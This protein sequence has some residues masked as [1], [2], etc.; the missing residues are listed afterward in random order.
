MTPFVE[1][2]NVELLES[3]RLMS[4]GATLGS[5]GVLSIQG[6]DAADVISVAPNAV[7][8]VVA[9]SIN[10]AY[11][12]FA[13]ASV[14][15]I[16]AKLG[17]GNDKFDGTYMNI[18]MTVDGEAGNDSILGGSANDYLIGGLDADYIFGGMGA[19]NI[20]GNGGKDFLSGGGGVDRLDG[21]KSNDVL[22]GGSGND[23]MIGG[24]GNDML[25][26]DDGDDLFYCGGVYSDTLLGG[27]GADRGYVDAD[28]KCY[29]IETKTMT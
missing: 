29:S 5:T 10:G 6:T 18:P 9:V 7:K 11:T 21:G 19:D 15:S 14:K 20:T 28:D 26:G 23:R 22:H 8:K 2:Q 3:R 13:L 4:A 24:E 17:L 16:S 1:R 12:L 27:N 25:Y